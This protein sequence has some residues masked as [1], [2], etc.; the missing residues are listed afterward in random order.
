MAA[1]P[2]SAASRAQQ[3][4]AMNQG[5]RNLLL[6]SAPRMRKNLG[7][8]TANGMGSTTR[9][10]LFNVGLITNLQCY[11]TCPITI[12]TST[13]TA[14]PRAPYNLISRVRLTDYDGTDRVN[15]SGFQLF[16]L[17]C[18][19]NRIPYGINNEGPIVT[20]QGSSV[21]SGII[22]N[23]STP[24]AVGS[25]TLAFL[26]DVPVAYDP[27]ADLRGCILGQTAVG[28]MTLSIDWAPAL[29]TA[30]NLDAVYTA[31]TTV[32]L[33]AVTGPSVQVWQE[34]LMPQSVQGQVPLPTIDLQT[35]YEMAGNIRDNAN[36]AVASEKLIPY[37]NVRSVIG[38]Y[39][40][41]MNGTQML[42]TDITQFR[43]IANGNNILRDDTQVSQIIRQRNYLE[44]D[45]AYGT[46]FFLHRSKPIETALY[47]NI[48]AGIT[49]NVVNSGAL[50]EFGFESFYVKGSALPG[51]TQS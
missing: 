30:S 14:S 18:V 21:L 6:S 15:W 1:A 9:I 38:G 17:N 34:Y 26:L 51:I 41:Y 44:G 4:L 32:T 8:F 35:V 37:P 10:P 24:T 2:Q 50:I 42:A 39:F 40:A 19:R 49:P 5:L 29:L 20:A 33:N 45:I 36:L 27:E 23:P 16:V 12:G 22:T 25:G 11:V 48:Q 47:G 3:A 31:G 46:Y 13:A 43:L 28:Q 7:T